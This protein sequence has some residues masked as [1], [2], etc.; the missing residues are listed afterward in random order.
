MKL[1]SKTTPK[2]LEKRP[3]RLENPFPNQTPV[4]YDIEVYPNYF[5]AVF[6][7]EKNVPISYTLNNIQD[8]IR[9]L[10][11]KKLYLIGF[12][13]HGYDDIIMKYIFMKNG[14]VQ[15]SD[16]RDLS[17]EIIFGD[18]DQRSQ[19]YWDLWW[20]EP[21]W[22]FSMDVFC[23][24]KK[25]VGLK[26]RAARRHWHKIQ[27]LPIDPDRT[28][29]Q[30]E[31]GQIVPYCE[32][33][34]RITIEEWNDIQRLIDIRK[35]LT[36]SMESDVL[37]KHNAAICETIIT[38]QYCKQTGFKKKFVQSQRAKP[39]KKINIA[40]CIPPWI[41]FKSDDLNQFLEKWRELSGRFSTDEDKAL[42]FKE[43]LKI[44]NLS[45]N[46]GAG[47]IHSNDKPLIISADGDYSLIDIDVASYYPNLIKSLKLKPNHMTST[48]NHILEDMT[49]QRLDA[50]RNGQKIKSDGLKIVINSAFGKTGNKWSIMFDEL[51]QLQVTLAGQLSLLMLMEMLHE[52]KILILSMNTDGILC[53]INKLEYTK[54]ASVCRQWEVLTQ[55]VLEETYYS[56]YIRR[57]VNN[58]LAIKSDGSTKE[59]GIFKR[60]IRGKAS[61]I[62]QALREYY[63]HENDIEDTIMSELDLRPFI[64]YTHV[65][66]GWK[67]FHKKY[68]ELYPIQKTSRWYISNAI[69][70]DGNGFR[71]SP[72][73][74]DIIKSGQMTR[75]ERDRYMAAHA[76]TEHP[77]D[78]WKFLSVP[79][80]KN[81]RLINDLPMVFP[82]DLDRQYYIDQCNDIIRSIKN[83]EKSET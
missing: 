68:G 50:K 3:F 56:K 31:M 47:G 52:E 22:S 70:R 15:A 11:D 10:S 79:H 54:L 67:L 55:C 20:Y 21:P 58:Y 44:G 2:W 18:K 23:I 78:W 35:E 77:D 19:L 28:L 14:N 83:E 38:D 41:E 61:I 29:T 81:S 76:T 42:L 80:G 4:V 33:D 69:E 7:G 37:S 27:D 13:N 36:D 57:D 9:T 17:T 46:L 26:E 64:F 30:D 62:A 72:L 71:P 25:E 51:M 63:I 8:M 60:H 32:N 82:D 1:L 66:M 74:G 12:N 53:Y 6:I 40:D 34:V 43:D 49:N 75:K 48:F 16:L 59:K 73:I 24:P 65:S 5:L 45:L 39:G